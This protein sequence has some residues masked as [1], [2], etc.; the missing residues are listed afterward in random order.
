MSFSKLHCAS[1]FRIEVAQGT[2]RTSYNLLTPVPTNTSSRCSFS[3]GTTI[4]SPGRDTQV[5]QGSYSS[6]YP[7]LSCAR[8]DRKGIR[9]EL[10]RNLC[11]AEYFPTL[12][13]PLKSAAIIAVQ[14]LLLRVNSNLRT[15]M[16]PITTILQ[17]T[18]NRGPCCNEGQSWYS[19][20]CLR[21]LSLFELVR[22]AA[23]M[24]W[25]IKC[26]KIK[27]HKWQGNVKGWLAGLLHIP[28]TFTTN[29][30]LFL[31]FTRLQ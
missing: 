18:Q 28:L 12:P 26:S 3:S 8:E 9:G 13:F 20:P 31:A 1:D 22:W 24:S 23:T 11:L 19:F 14:D 6:L 5:P 2:G 29:L 25:I 15:L 16:L 7:F 27:Q 10:C 30:R 4:H 17:G 21:A